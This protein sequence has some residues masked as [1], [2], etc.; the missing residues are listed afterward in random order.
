MQ[1][2]NRSEYISAQTSEKVI[3]AQVDARTR[4]YV[5]S[6]PTLNIYSKVVPYF[7]QA[8]T[9]LKNQPYTPT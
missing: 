8:F 1:F 6:G 9:I 2:L 7:V 5:F 3:L 4:L